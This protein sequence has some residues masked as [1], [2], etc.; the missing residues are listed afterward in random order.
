MNKSVGHIIRT[1]GSRRFGF[2]RIAGKD[3]FFHSDDLINSNWDYIDEYLN[4][5]GQLDVECEITESPKGLRVGMIR[6]LGV[7]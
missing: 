2:I 4:N 5:T 7:E 3:Y 6:V 1:F